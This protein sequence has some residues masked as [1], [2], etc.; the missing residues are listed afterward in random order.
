MGATAYRQ[1]KY[2][3]PRSHALG[4]R[5]AAQWAA[6]L[7]TPRPET[8]AHLVGTALPAAPGVKA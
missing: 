6:K 1:T 5:R 2:P 7:L 8:W 3:N 4:F